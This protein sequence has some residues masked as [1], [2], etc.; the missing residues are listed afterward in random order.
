MILHYFKDQMYSDSKIEI[1]DFI[2]FTTCE[3][4]SKYKLG[5][6]LLRTTIDNK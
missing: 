6:A 4:I 5:S 1:C 2:F 3:F